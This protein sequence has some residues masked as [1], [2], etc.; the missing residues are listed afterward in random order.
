[1]ASV[2]KAQMLDQFEPEHVLEI[3]STLDPLFEKEEFEESDHIAELNDMFEKIEL[4][5]LVQV[6]CPSP[7][8]GR[9]VVFRRRGVAA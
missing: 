4:D 1:M 2:I 9:R 6:L 8:R 7:I 5:I 3:E